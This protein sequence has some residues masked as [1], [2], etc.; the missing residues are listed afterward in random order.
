M[1]KLR[2]DDDAPLPL[3]TANLPQSIQ[4]HVINRLIVIHQL[5]LT[6][7]TELD[8]E[9]LLHIMLSGI[10]A[11]EALGFNRALV[12][13][14]DSGGKSLVGKMAVGPINEEECRHVWQSLARKNLHLDD[15][16]NEFDQ[17][18][19]YQTAPINVQ[20]KEI[21]WPLEKGGRDI[22][23]R[24]IEEKT[25]FHITPE[26]YLDAVPEPVTDLLE[27]NEMI[28]APLVVTGK[29]L[30][31]V[32]AD[33]KFSGRPIPEED[34][35]LLS[36][37]A[38]QT[39]AAL[40]HI[41]LIQELEKF[42]TVLEEKVREAVAEKEKA[43]GEMIRSAKFATVGEMAVTIAHEIR[44]PLTAVRGFAQRLLRKS[45]DTET[46]RNYSEIIVQEVDRLNHVLGDVLDFAKNVD[47]HLSPVNLN[48]IIQNAV[49]LLQERFGRSNILCEMDLDPKIPI[50]Y[51]DGPQLTQVLINLMK[52]GAEAMKEGGVLEVRTKFEDGC[53]SLEVAD[54]GCGIP[55]KEL[56][57]IFEPFFTTKT[58]GTGLGLAFAKRVVEE[59]G[60][61]IYAKSE[62]GQGTT[63]HICL[64]I[65]MKRPATEDV[66]ESMGLAHPLVD[67]DDPFVSFDARGRNRAENEAN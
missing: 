16:V 40:S 2:T 59:H 6:L 38:N 46:V 9:R 41:H 57:S 51:Y 58:R 11:G 32:I 18:K 64:P 12:F 25:C 1:K 49:T 53:C 27:V 61:Q 63:F 7:Q 44:N 43:Q 50:C 55:K 5:S 26:H 19:K 34:I 52:N 29:A 4:A 3:Q 17:F 24:T 23:A 21:T 20:T 62:C 36:I 60:G 67:R 28:T 33:N 30:G 56:H 10:T 15:F 65:Q 48:E 14:L 39:A 13:L 22:F 47:T 35:Q 66:I 8:E 45:D 54:T 31:L 37:V 42:Y